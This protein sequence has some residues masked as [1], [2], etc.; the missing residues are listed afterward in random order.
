M[1]QFK[2]LGPLEILVGERICAPSQPKVR[3]VLALL[4]LRVGRVVPVDTLIEE[5]WGFESPPTAVA[6]VQ[7]YICQLRRMFEEQELNPR[8]GQ[9]VVTRPPGYRIGVESEQ[10]DAAIFERLARQGRMLLEA[11]C[12]SE[13]AAILHRAL[14]MWTGPALADVRRG[15]LLEAHAVHLEERRINTLELQIKADVR[16]G[17]HR[18]LIGELRSLVSAHPLNEWFH[19]QLMV[20]LSR[21]GRRSEALQ[22]YHCLQAVLRGELGVNPSPELQRLQHQVLSAGE[23]LDGTRVMSEAMRFPRA[24]FRFQA[25][26]PI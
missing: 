12:T 25:D 19:G 15:N 3:S 14:D 20:A 7:T 6:T 2:V 23:F 18:E 1:A 16:L 10:L 24:H 4:L 22:V 21:S 9:L 13:A 26:E 8:G 5:L 11:G 17:K